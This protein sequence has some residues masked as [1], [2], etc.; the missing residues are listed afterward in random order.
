MK[1]HAIE[2][3]NMFQ[4]YQMSKV[5]FSLSILNRLELTWQNVIVDYYLHSSPSLMAK[6]NTVKPN[7]Q[8]TI[9]YLLIY[10]SFFDTAWGTL[11]RVTTN[12]SI[13]LHSKRS[14]P[15]AWKFVSNTLKKAKYWY[16]LRSAVVGMLELVVS[17]VIFGKWDHQIL[18]HLD[19]GATHR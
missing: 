5:L 9:R 6:W 12:F 1:L 4:M 3:R 10:S 16:D 7:D 17:D 15:V 19:L 18:V 11:V 2:R 14:L 13:G 8:I